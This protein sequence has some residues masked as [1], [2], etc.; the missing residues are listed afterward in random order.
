M[1]IEVL[2][3]KESTSTPYLDRSKELFDDQFGK[4]LKFLL[5]PHLFNPLCLHLCLGVK[6]NGKT[7]C[8]KRNKGAPC[9]KNHDGYG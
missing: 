1:R 5:H 6:R 3:G 4:S 7:I 2:F 8:I 9:F